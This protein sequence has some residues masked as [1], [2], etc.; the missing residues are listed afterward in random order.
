M[1]R[2]HSFFPENMPGGWFAP[3]A[4]V[5]FA[6]NIALPSMAVNAEYAVVVDHSCLARPGMVMAASSSLMLARPTGQASPLGFT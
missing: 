2:C 3:V 6:F 5:E 1:V 4:A